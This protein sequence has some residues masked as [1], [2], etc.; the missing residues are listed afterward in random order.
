[1]SQW[2]VIIMDIVMKEK[3]VNLTIVLHTEGNSYVPD[4][5][6]QLT[7]EFGGKP[8]VDDISNR[9]MDKVGFD[10]AGKGVYLQKQGKDYGVINK[11]DN[12]IQVKAGQMVDI[13]ITK[14]NVGPESNPTA[15]D[16]TVSVD[17][18]PVGHWRDIGSN[19]IDGIP[20]YYVITGSPP[21]RVRYRQDGL[22]NCYNKSCCKQDEHRLGPSILCGS[23]W[24]KPLPNLISV[25]SPKCFV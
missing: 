12:S 4:S 6:D 7:L 25:W 24:Y 1:M 8:H 11:V 22:L 5:H 9:A 23:L 14:Q 16:I 13:Q 19:P 17:G 2:N 18:R 20:P 21:A 10:E 15:V 3:E